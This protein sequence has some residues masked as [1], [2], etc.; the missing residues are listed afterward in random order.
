[1][2]YER[3]NFYELRNLHFQSKGNKFD[4]KG[5]NIFTGQGFS[6]VSYNVNLSSE[7]SLLKNFTSN[8]LTN[9]K[10][11]SEILTFDK[12]TGKNDLNTVL[13]F[14]AV[15]PLSSNFV[16][17]AAINRKTDI[18]TVSFTLKNTTAN[19][20]QAVLVK[21]VDDNYCTVSMIDGVTKKFL[22]REDDGK[23]VS[24]KF[25][26]NEELLTPT[27]TSF[28]YYSYNHD[29]DNNYLKLYNDNKILTT[30]VRALTSSFETVSSSDG[31]TTNFVA[32][33]T[34]TSFLN[35]PVLSTP[36]IVNSRNGLIKIDQP[37]NKL[38]NEFL[39]QYIYYDFDNNYKLSN[40]TLSSVDYNL[41]TYFPYS[42]ISLS[43]TDLSGSSNNFYVDLDFFNLKNQLSNDNIVYSE[44]NV[45][46]PTQQRQYFNFT[47]NRNSEK[48]E[49]NLALN[50][51]F[52]NKEYE[53]LPNKLTK[54]IMPGSI[55]PYKKININD[56]TLAGNGAFAAKSPYFSDK[57]F[58]NTNP[59]EN[60]LQEVFI[61]TE[62]FLVD[63]DDLSFILLQDDNILGFQNLNEI[64]RNDI[65]GSYLCT[66]LKEI[67]NDT[68]EWYDRYYLTDKKSFQVS[69]SGST[70]ENSFDNL[71]QAKKYFDNNPPGTYYFDVRSNLTF[72]P[73]GSYLYQRIGKDYVNNMIDN[74]SSKLVKSNFDVLSSG[75]RV[76]TTDKFDFNELKGYDNFK[77][78]E[79]KENSFHLSFDLELE[80]L[81]SYDSYQVLG[82]MYND[83]ISV[84]S[85]YYF[86][87]F[88]FIP[89]KNNLKIYDYKFNL[90][91]DITF[92]DVTDIID[93]LYMEQNN[94][95]VIICSNKIFKTNVF[96][97][98]LAERTLD[99]YNDPLLAEV[100]KGYKT[101]SYYGSN[102]VLI[103]THN[104]G[105]SNSVIYN[106]NLN[107][108]SITDLDMSFSSTSANLGVVYSSVSGVAV[109]TLGV[110]S[111]LVNENFAISNDKEPRFTS[112]QFIPGLAF[113]GT[114]LEFTFLSGI[115]AGRSFDRDIYLEILGAETP[116][117]SD[118]F[119][120]VE[121]DNNRI[122]F[123]DLT[124][125][126]EITPI[127]DSTNSVINFNNTVEDKIYFQIFNN[128]VGTLQIINS[129]RYFLSAF[130]L[131]ESANDG[132]GVDFIYENGDWK[133]LSF[134]KDSNGHVV[135]DK[136]NTI[137]GAIEDSTTL[138]ISSNSFKQLPVYYTQEKLLVTSANL[139]FPTLSSTFA[140]NMT[141][142]TPSGALSSDSDN[143]QKFERVSRD[144]YVKLLNGS[145]TGE[146]TGI[147]SFIFQQLPVLSANALHNTFTGANT[148][149]TK[150]KNVQDELSIKIALDTS[151][152][153]SLCTVNWD[154]AGPPV[155]ATGFD[156]F[157]WNFPQQGL[158][159][160]DG[161]ITFGTS[162]S[163]ANFEAIY[164]IPNL[165]I[166]NHINLDFNMNNGVIK[167]YN[168]SI[169]FGTINF[170]PNF[171][172]VDRI[173][174]PD[175]FINTQNINNQAIETVSNTFSSDEFKGKNI[176][177][178]NF[179]LY[180]NSMNSDIVNYLNIQSVDVDTLY[181]DMY[182][183]T[184]NNVEELDSL[185][186]YKIPGAK[187]NTGK[188]Y[189]KN[190]E[191]SDDNITN[192]IKYISL[193]LNNKT[194]F[195]MQQF[196]Y[197][198]NN[199]EYHIMDDGTVMTGDQ[200]SDDETYV[201]M[202]SA[203]EVNNVI[204]NDTNDNDTRSTY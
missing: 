120:F 193:N 2:A 64:Q 176:T 129:E 18:S 167:L 97:V 63:Q 80:S 93:V 12:N 14:K 179:K 118:F 40:E 110:D 91:N 162:V 25:L 89:F 72:E 83:G 185:Y 182:S 199:K 19:N 170:D 3:K 54:L 141:A 119:D 61:E 172:V 87:P 125:S 155:S 95:L 98:R 28:Y 200:H 4:Y 104:E 92:N 204:S 65:F 52:F 67:D 189:I 39:D 191:I 131:S 85:N 102:N 178:D 188:I 82:N 77:I 33:I 99:N 186:N 157:E 107:N 23:N 161:L 202:L 113:R 146:G 59:N 123:D 20:G 197:V 115:A 94:D 103:R 134:C 112:N 22:Y 29:V 177:L 1:M 164:K 153:P 135:I 121:E 30:G 37:I 55:F 180:N 78:D 50:Y 168:N 183:G 24:F 51:T 150:Y 132:M 133:V 114:D 117:Y 143:I 136:F 7:S 56:T 111:I 126:G 44:S 105:G 171:I 76:I 159:A 140:P 53:I 145:A 158:S 194:P 31:G 137:T 36:D 187:N 32:T 196:A 101:K 10:N 175:I 11:S 148:L 192:L 106:L 86:T 152:N 46:N 62:E 5:D 16:A 127:I 198:V 184:K 88:I 74:Q 154:I 163:G 100:L 38:G 42:D 8:T 201:G 144:D 108:L 58:K 166:N 34:T 69:L 17:I 73:N 173:L 96:G 75:G 151:F 169:N 124:Y 147:K 70:S 116:T 68:N 81:S 156:S 27:L 109:P 9:Q 138:T 149:Y 45:D 165:R 203:V 142:G 160:W 84:K 190:I 130:P 128:N 35:A 79:F 49:E 57:V 90:I 71:S 47:N 195:N 60:T 139:G 122:I 26:S 174:K 21:F 41:I 13:N 6:Y 43:G 15:D 48:S 66:W 181:F